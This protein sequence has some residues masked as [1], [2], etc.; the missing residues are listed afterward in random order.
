MTIELSD[1]RVLRKRI[2]HAIGSLEKPMSDK[3]PRAQIRR[4]RRRHPAKEQTAKLMEL[5][6]SVENSRQ[7]RRNRPSRRKTDS[8]ARPN[9]RLSTP[10]S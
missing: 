1:G 10:Y 6:W 7:R 4:S 2:E 8:L 3:R 5:C 9:N